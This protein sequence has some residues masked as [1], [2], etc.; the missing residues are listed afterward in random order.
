ML[1]YIIIKNQILFQVIIAGKEYLTDYMTNVTPNILS[2]V[3]ANLHLHKSHPLGHLCKRIVHFMHNYYINS[4]GN[5]LFSVYDKLFQVVTVEQNFDSLLVAPN[6]VTRKKRDNYYIN[7]KHLLRAHTTAHQVC[8][9]L[10]YYSRLHGVYKI[11]QKLEFSLISGFLE[12]FK[13]NL[14]KIQS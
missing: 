3:G 4:R 12:D 14:W 6:H 10:I 1:F 9:L 13:L 2:K 7:S 5:P 8:S 11:L